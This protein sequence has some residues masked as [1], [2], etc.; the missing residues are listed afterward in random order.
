MAS[1]PQPHW[2]R[3][4]LRFPRADRLTAAIRRPPHRRSCLG[5][6]GL[7]SAAPGRG[8]SCRSA[9]RSAS[10]RCSRQQGPR[11]V[12]RIQQQAG[13]GRQ[14]MRQAGGCPCANPT[15]PGSPEARPTPRCAAVALQPRP[16]SRRSQRRRPD[17]SDTRKPS[18]CSLSPGLWVRRL[19]I[20]DSFLSVVPP[21]AN[22]AACLIYHWP[23]CY[24]AK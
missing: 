22:N 18:H 15:A 3:R 1:C 16:P 19:L 14:W 9:G 12:G 17:T 11:R 4:P 7:A 10:G 2:P 6:C 5:R 8:Q 20:H 24:S 21:K 23:Q 13:T